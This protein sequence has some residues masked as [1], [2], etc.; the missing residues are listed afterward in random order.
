MLFLLPPCFEVFEAERV[1]RTLKNPACLAV[2]VASVAA[3]FR[4]NYLKLIGNSPGLK[5][6]ACLVARVAPVAALFRYNYFKLT[7]LVQA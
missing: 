7:G 5:S 4:Y 1:S 6:P 3:L 2:R